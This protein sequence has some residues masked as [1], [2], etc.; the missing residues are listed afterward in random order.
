MQVR[1]EILSL[2]KF[3]YA[4]AYLPI[5]SYALGNY[6]YFLFSDPAEVTDF[7]LWPTTLTENGNF[8]INCKMVGNPD[9]VWSVMNNRTKMAMMTAD[10]AA[11]VSLTSWPVGCEDAGFWMC[12]GHN[13]LN[14]NMNT[15]QGSNVTVFCKYRYYGRTS[16]KL[17]SVAVIRKCCDIVAYR[18]G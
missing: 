15:T 4:L 10:M 3:H 18:H 9:P 7:S 2:T 12:T 17:E 6:I 14:K 5:G 11:G 8:T 16:L 13:Y 1:V